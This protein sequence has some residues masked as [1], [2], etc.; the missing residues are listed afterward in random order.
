MTPPISDI[1]AADDELSSGLGDLSSGLVTCGTLLDGYAKEH[2]KADDVSEF[3]FHLVGLVKLFGR[4]ATRLDDLHCDIRRTKGLWGV[5]RARPEKPDQEAENK[6]SK[7]RATKKE[8]RQR[9]RK[10]GAA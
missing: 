2:D 7:H 5:R 3:L 1:E 8:P 9:R 10:G 4:F 6:S